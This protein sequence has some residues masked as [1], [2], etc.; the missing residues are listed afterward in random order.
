M[1]PPCSDDPPLIQLLR[2][3]GSYL[4]DAYY[5]PSEQSYG[6]NAFSNDGF[7]DS[8]KVLFRIIYNC[9]TLIART[10]GDDPIFIGAPTPS[11]PEPREVHLSNNRTP[12]FTVIGPDTVWEDDPYQLL[13]HVFDPDS[14]QVSFSFLQAPSWLNLNEETGLLSGTPGAADLGTEEVSIVADDGYFRGRDTLT[15]SITVL[16]VNHAPAAFHLLTPEYIDTIEYHPSD[17]VE[18][19]WQRAIDPDAG[20]VVGYELVIVS[21]TLDTIRA[22]TVDTMLRLSM[23]E[24]SPSMAYAWSVFSSDGIVTTAS[25]DTFFFFTA[26]PEDVKQFPGIPASYSLSQN[27]PNP[28]NPTTVINF[29]LP[30]SGYVILNI[31]NVLGE[32]VATLVDESLESGNKS[33]Q[34]DASGLPSGVYVYRLT[35][36][37][38]NGNFYVD[39]KKLVLMR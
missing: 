11:P 7:N 34:L 8:D 21:L 39:A 25:A 4:R 29:Q 27:Y 3:D 23:T 17:S 20:D 36:Q 18:F 12:A 16:H 5:N 6:V 2:S 35:A 38:A 28:F 30:V 31:Y 26:P 22:T 37:E 24:L 13:L 10:H 14:D 19:S 32:E 9:D 15:F 33:V 1:P